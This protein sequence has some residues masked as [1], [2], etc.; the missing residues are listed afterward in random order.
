[1]C[2]KSVGSYIIKT[3]ADFQ[4]SLS[5]SM[6]PPCYIADQPGQLI[7]HAHAQ[8]HDSEDNPSSSGNYRIST[9]T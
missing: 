4:Q 6:K 8:V 1:M 9:S 5:D 3:C 2:A 7:P